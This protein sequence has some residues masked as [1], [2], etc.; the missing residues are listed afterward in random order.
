MI[1]RRGTPLLAAFAAVLSCILLSSYSEVAARVFSACAAAL[2]S[3]AAAVFLLRKHKNARNAGLYLAAAGLGFLLGAILLVRMDRD[4]RSVS[5]AVP[6]ADVSGF[7]CVLSSDSSL[8]RD[9]QTI[10]RVT[11]KGVES[12]NIGVKGGANAGAVVV[13]QGDYRFSLGEVLRIRSGLRL[14]GSGGH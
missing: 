3:A 12:G 13:L 4:A 8:S 10:L 2:A 6:A 1:P 5:L 14:L 7:T 9:S 11:V